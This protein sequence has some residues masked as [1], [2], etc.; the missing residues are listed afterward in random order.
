MSKKHKRKRGP[1]KRPSVHKPP[2]PVT[3][4]PAPSKANP[5][6]AALVIAMAAA[7]CIGAWL[8]ISPQLEKQ[9]MLAHQ[10]ELLESITSGDGVIVLEDRFAAGDVDF[11]SDG[12]EAPEVEATLLAAPIEAIELQPVSMETA[13]PQ[14]TE[15]VG[16]G[17]LYI[18]SINAVLPVTDGVSAAQLKVAVGHVPQTAPIGGEGNAVIAGHRSYTYGDYFNRLDEVAVGDLI[19]YEDRNGAAFTYKVY[20]TLVIEPGDPTAFDQPENVQILTLYT[21]TPVRTATHR[22]LVRAAL[23]SQISM[24][25]ESN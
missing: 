1:I 13:A 23:I 24:E 15:I 5:K 19:R 22:L 4:S 20:E 17:V 2:Q 21:C 6:T 12:A 10:S 16:T 11:Y 25:E 18:D 3:A 7:L 9:Q 8:L 14:S